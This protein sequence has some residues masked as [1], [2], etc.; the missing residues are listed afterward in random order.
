MGGIA[1]AGG[2]RGGNDMIRKLQAAAQRIQTDVRAAV[3]DEG[4]RLLDKAEERVPVDTGELRDSGHVIDATEGDTIAAEIE[5]D[6]PHALVVHE[7]LEAKHDDGQAKFL[8]S[9]LKEN[10]KT[11][12]ANI[13]EK[14]R[15]T[16]K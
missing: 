2:M 11:V 9:V 12:V 5:F 10:A 13:G 15:D 14:L 4:E 16:L 6:A 1:M 8:E 3:N 7:D